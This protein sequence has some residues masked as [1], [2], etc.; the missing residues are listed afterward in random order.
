[1]TTTQIPPSRAAARPVPAPGP[2]PGSSEDVEVLGLDATDA[3]GWVV[4]QRRAQDLAAARELRGVAHWAD[5]HRV[6]RAD[7]ARGFIGAAHPDVSDS[8][9]RSAGFVK[10]AVAENGVEGVLRS[11]GE[12]AFMV[13]EYA[14]SELA[15]ALGLGEHAGRA[16]VG[17]AVELRER[18]PRCWAKVMA[19]ALPAWKARRIAERTIPL[20]AATAAAV[21]SS[22]APFAGKLSTGRI[23]RAVDAAI[24]RHEPDLTAERDAAAAEKRGVWFEDRLDGTTDLAGL[25]DTPDACALDHALDT[26][27]T[28]LGQ[29]G[30]TDRRDVRRARALGALADPQ[31]A[32]DLARTA[33]QHAEQQAQERA[34]QGAPVTG[35]QRPARPARPTRQVP[36]LH[37]HLHLD[38]LRTLITNGDPESGPQTGPQTGPVSGPDTAC[39]ASSDRAEIAD[40]MADDVADLIRVDRAGLRLG[41]RTTATLERWLTGLTPGTRLTITPVIDQTTEIAV[42]SYEIPPQLRRQVVERD[43]TCTFPWCGNAGRHDLDHLDP[44]RP[45]DDGGPPHPHRQTRTKNLG[46]LCRFHHR[47]KT[48][49]DWTVQRDQLTGDLT[50]TSPHARRYRVTPTGTTPLDLP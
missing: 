30:D 29:L 1:M 21:D 2:V 44:W 50:W 8:F 47:L 4:G 15:T 24:L 26:M 10:Q 28:T 7:I 43:D 45:P 27:A 37:L 33:Q 42:D 36:T 17:Q 18:L 34:G 46:R 31:Y 32:L 11:A 5:L 14:V 35:A 41:A 23:D 6:G 39:G 25:L 13:E 20:H 38:A 48:N 16:Y 40:E 22:L 49:G 19:G 3:L 12:G 9:A